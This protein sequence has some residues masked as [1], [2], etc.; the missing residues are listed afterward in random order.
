M[1]TVYCAKKS[2]SGYYYMRQ[3]VVYDDTETQHN[4]NLTD[5]GYFG[6]VNLG[7]FVRKTLVIMSL[8]LRPDK[9]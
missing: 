3:V 4:N 9:L 5:R 1:Y 8:G 2:H 7:N 6:K